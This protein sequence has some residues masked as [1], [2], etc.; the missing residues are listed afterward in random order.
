M[1]GYTR[2]VRS[3]GTQYVQNYAHLG[4]LSTREDDGVRIALT[5]AFLLQLATKQVLEVVRGSKIIDKYPEKNI[6]VGTL[7]GQGDQVRRVV[8]NISPSRFDGG[9]GGHDAAV[10]L[11]RNWSSL[12]I[13][14]LMRPLHPLRWHDGWLSCTVKFNVHST[15]VHW[16]DYAERYISSATYLSPVLSPGIAAEAV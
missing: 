7:R 12:G 8:S 15:I 5:P 1:T 9:T 14:M 6:F 16:T 3:L 10:L 2:C 13:F 11:R 4:G